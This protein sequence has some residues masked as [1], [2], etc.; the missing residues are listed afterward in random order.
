[1]SAAASGYEGRIGRYGS[2]LATAFLQVV[3]VRPGW[4]ALDVGCGTGA[5]TTQLAARLGA[6][7]VAAVDPASEDVEVCRSRLPGVDVREAGAEALPFPDDCFDV[8]LAQLV[9]SLMCDP[10]AGVREMRRVAR[11]GRPVA[12]C[13]WDF[14]EGMT[15]LRTFWDA[16]A[17]LDPAARSADQARTRPLGTPAELQA[18]FERAGL[19]DV[20]TGQLIARADYTDF[21]DL[22]EP[23]VAP[24]GPPG[25]YWI[26]L[27]A[28]NREALREEM[29]QRLGRPDRAFELTARAWYVRATA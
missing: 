19:D 23:L 14:A 2:S 15:L 1:M 12:A 9:V 3:E 11:L 7:N 26:S 29:W 5:L 22:W 6:H 18:L 24:D 27:D 16:A 8:V 25:A 4:R 17:Q 28:A 10:D 21:E 20:R 13:G